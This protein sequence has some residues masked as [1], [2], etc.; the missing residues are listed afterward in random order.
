[1]LFEGTLK[2]FKIF[3]V[4]LYGHVVKYQWPAATHDP[5][6]LSFSLK[7]P[8]LLQVGRSKGASISSTGSLERRPL[9]WDKAI[10]G[11]GAVWV[12]I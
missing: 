11:K 3:S 5:S 4:D 10:W 1:M 8:L 12:G 2:I 7:L 9:C 6:T